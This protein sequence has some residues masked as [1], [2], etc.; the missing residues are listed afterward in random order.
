[1]P[2]GLANLPNLTLTSSAVDTSTQ[3]VTSWSDIEDAESMS[4]TVNGNTSAPGLQVQVCYTTISTGAFFP[5]LYQSSGAGIVYVTSGALPIWPITFKQAR[6][7]T[8]GVTSTGYTIL[9][10]KQFLF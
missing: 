4:I 6:V 9:A 7:G 8:S 10:V 2:R 1:M 3:S 5:L